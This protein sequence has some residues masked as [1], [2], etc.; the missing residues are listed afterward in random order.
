VGQGA[1]DR[2]RGVRGRKI[3][4]VREA[5]IE[6]KVT[7]FAKSKGWISFKWVSPSQKGVPDRIYFRRGEIM[8]VEFKAPGKHPTKLQNHIHKKLKDVGFEVHVI[9]DIDRGKELLC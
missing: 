4:K 3:P 1:P 9:D 6:K 8:L 2:G 5:T 7:D